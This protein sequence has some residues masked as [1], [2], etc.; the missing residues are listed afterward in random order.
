MP[1]MKYPEKMERKII[2]YMTKTFKFIR[3]GLSVALIAGMMVAATATASYSVE[4]PRK[5]SLHYDVYAGGFKAL[6]ASLLMD[7]DKKAYDMKLQAETQ[8]FIG[9]IFPWKTSLNTSGHTEKGILIPTV[10]TES[11]TWRQKVKV[12]EMCY[13]PNGKVLKTTTQDNGTTTVDRDINEVLADNT[14]DVLTGA[15]MIF[16]NVKNTNK[17]AGKFPIF[18]GK[19]RFN[20]TLT[21]D[22]DEVLPETGYSSFK[23]AALRCTLKVEPVAGFKK[24]DEKRGWMAVQNHTEQHHKLPTIWLARTP[25]SSQIVPVRMEIASD[26]GSVVAHLANGMEH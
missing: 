4:K 6:N 3:A 11:S 13:A 19:R 25:D 21:D 20:I 22:G 24:R 23:G 17:C 18:D 12:T 15:L 14:M 5:L 7:L 16:Q 10:Y 26:Y 8:G 2:S 1:R 9:S